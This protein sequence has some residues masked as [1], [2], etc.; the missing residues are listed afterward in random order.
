V[1]SS[2]KKK[3][4]TVGD[5]TLT[6]GKFYAD[7]E[8]DSGIQTGP[9]A[10]FFAITSAFKKPVNTEGKTLVVQARRARSEQLGPRTDS[11]CAPPLSSP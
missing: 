8:R 1:K 3:D 11:C 9:D 10:R 4:G 5:W 6:P 2:W 7:K